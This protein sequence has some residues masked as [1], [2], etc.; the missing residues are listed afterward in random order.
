MS[1]F[2]AY[3]GLPYSRRLDCYG[4]LRKV[5]REVAGIDLPDYRYPADPAGRAAFAKGVM[6]DWLPVLRPRPLD[7]VLIEDAGEPRHVGLVVR[8]GCML[9]TDAVL[10]RARIERYDSGLYQVAG[11]YRWGGA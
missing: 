6:A 11:F 5:L 3:V 9:H 4:L 1:D 8:R 7:I 10:G 2:S